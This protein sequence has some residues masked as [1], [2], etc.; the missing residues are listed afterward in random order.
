[1][2][3]RKKINLDEGTVVIKG[4][5][6]G[7][8]VTITGNV[9]TLEIEQDTPD[10]P[11]VLDKISLV[12]NE[13]LWMKLSHH[14]SDGHLYKIKLDGFKVK[15][16]ASVALERPSSGKEIERARIR[17]GAPKKAAFSRTSEDDQITFVWEEVVYD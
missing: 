15:K 5:H 4:K 9:A 1:M 11:S 7:Q 2:L 6:K 16:R 13:P 10:F 14:I 3:E 17:A 12:R 8:G